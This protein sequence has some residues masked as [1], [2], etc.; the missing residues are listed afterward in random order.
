MYTLIAGERRWRASEIAGLERVPV[1]IREVSD[2]PKAELALMENVQRADLS[3]LE[4][5]EAYPRTDRRL[6]PFT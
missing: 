1:I 4:T 5:A 3:P 6:Q 2:Q